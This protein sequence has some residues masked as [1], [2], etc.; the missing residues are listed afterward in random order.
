MKC[1][2][3][4]APPV[5]AGVVAVEV[6][7]DGGVDADVAGAA[8]GTAGWPVDEPAVVV[9]ALLVWSAVAGD[10]GAI[11]EGSAAGPDGWVASFWTLERRSMSGVAAGRVVDDP[12]ASAPESTAGPPTSTRRTFRLALLLAERS[13]APASRAVADGDAVSVSTS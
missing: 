8:V 9:V 6:V 11:V 13:E 5:S 3:Q 2:S 10:A 4:T 1:S 12:S 7:V